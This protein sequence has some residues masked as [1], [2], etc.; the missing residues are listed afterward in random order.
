M[1]TQD[2]L[3][4]FQVPEGVSIVD[5]AVFASLV[6]FCDRVPVAG[7]VLLG[8]ALRF[9]DGD[10]A[11]GEF[12]GGEGVGAGFVGGGRVGDIEGVLEVTGGVLLG[13][14]EGV[15]DPEAGFDVSVI[16]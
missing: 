7:V 16:V 9:G 14:E 6:H 11:V 2:E 10:G 4:G 15:E 3:E 5:K 1:G 12:S 13:D 8:R